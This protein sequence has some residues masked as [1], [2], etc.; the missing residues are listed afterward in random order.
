MST[1]D[2]ILMVM[3]LI[4]AYLGYRKGFLMELVNTSSFIF[5]IFFAV[6]FWYVGAAYIEKNYEAMP[7]VVP[8]VGFLLIFIAVLISVRLIGRIVKT[9][10]SGTLIGSM[11]Q[12]LGALL[13]IVKWVI[14][15]STFLWVILKYPVLGL[16]Q[17]I[18]KSIICTALVKCMGKVVAYF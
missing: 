3:L 18:Y 14:G 12:L 10:L 2:I 4:G 5:G 16:K 11:D 7:H 9:S 6:K 17:V 8:I 15:V 1:I 13:G